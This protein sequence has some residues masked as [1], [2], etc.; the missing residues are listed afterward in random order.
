MQYAFLSLSLFTHSPQPLTQHVHCRPAPHSL[1]CPV[2]PA[3]HVVCLAHLGPQVLAIND[4][5][6]RAEKATCRGIIAIAHLHRLD[7]PRQ[8]F[9]RTGIAQ[10]LQC[11][12]P[13]G[14]T[15]KKAELD[16]RA[17]QYTPNGWTCRVCS[18]RMRP[19]EIP[20]RALRAQAAAPSALPRTTST[21]R[22][23]SRATFSKVLPVKASRSVLRPWEPSTI[24][25][26][27]FS[28]ATFRA[29]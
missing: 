8:A 21:G 4:D 15:V 16:L 12:F 1:R 6:R 28:S 19:I 20:L 18:D 26:E 9:Q 7:G 2:H 25:P 10:V 5:G 24:K 13:R 14:A 29:S 23:L 27:S 11:G 3:N 17:A 22:R